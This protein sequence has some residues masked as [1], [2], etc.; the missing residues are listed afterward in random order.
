MANRLARR[1][2]L[3]AEAERIIT[4]DRNK[5]YGEPD[6][7]FQRIAAIASAMGFRALKTIERPDGDTSEFVPLT[8][9][10]VAKFM[11]CLKLSR[12][13]W[14]PTHR[15]SWL[16]IAGYAGCGYETAS[17]E[18]ERRTFAAESTKRMAS[19]PDAAL[20]LLEPG[21][22]AETVEQANKAVAGDPSELEA[23]GWILTDHPTP[24]QVCSEACSRGHQFVQDCAYRIRRRR[25]NA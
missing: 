25:S 17:L 11:I 3:L 23:A 13:A 7:D 16:D 15:D 22:L 18:Q 21:A 12:L 19:S 1:A 8:G 6:E 4:Q 10:D 14:M 24:F 9:S 20:W 2:E 5:S